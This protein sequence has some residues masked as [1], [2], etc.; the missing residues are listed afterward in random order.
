MHGQAARAAAEDDFLHEGGSA[1]PAQVARQ[2]GAG[3]RAQG[4]AV[5]VEPIKPTLKAPGTKR[6]KLKYYKLLSTS[7][8]KFKLRRY[9]KDRGSDDDYDEDE[10]E[11]VGTGHITLATSSIAWCT[12]ACNAIHHIVYRRSPRHPPYSLPVLVASSTMQCTGAC[13]IIRKTE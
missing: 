1:G 5:Q 7:A 8:V 10:D 11:E 2:A 13:H 4:K 12:G 6:L 3:R 9:S